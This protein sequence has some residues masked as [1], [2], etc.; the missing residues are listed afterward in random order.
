VDPN[1]IRRLLGTAEMLSREKSSTPEA[2]LVAFVAWEGLKFRMLV[3]FSPN[4]KKRRS[5]PTTLTLAAFPAYPMFVQGS[6]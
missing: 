3:V 6:Q 2:F 5:P 4:G 1:E